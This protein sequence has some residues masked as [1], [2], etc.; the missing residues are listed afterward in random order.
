MYSFHPILPLLISHSAAFSLSLGFWLGPPHVRTQ[1]T[2]LSQQSL[3]VWQ[4]SPSGLQPGTSLAVTDIIDAVN[5]IIMAGKT[6]R[7]VCLGW[8]DLLRYSNDLFNLSLLVISWV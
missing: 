8:Y 6:K 5:A 4:L 3:A 2:F 7:I 1:S